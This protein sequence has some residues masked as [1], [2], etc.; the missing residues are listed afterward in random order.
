MSETSAPLPRILLVDN[1]PAILDSLKEE[2]VR[3]PAEVETVATGNAAIDLFVRSAASK[4]PFRI[5]VLDMWIPHSEGDEVDTEGGLE[6]L[7]AINHF[8]LVDP[9]CFIIVFTGH[10]RYRDCVDCV[11]SH[12]V[13]YIP[14]VG[15][16]G[17]GPEEV[18][19]L[20]RRLLYPI[21]EDDPFEAWSSKNMRTARAKYDHKVIALFRPD[22]AQNAGLEGELLDGFVIVSRESAEEVGMLM[23]NNKILRWERPMLINY[24]DV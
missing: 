20:C 13:D 14:K 3:L 23:L 17:T 1:D 5:V 4:K 6:T 18:I 11:K 8:H 19:N 2:L 10:E 9:R 16:E 22:V 15:D 24:K 21:P 12:A 7:R